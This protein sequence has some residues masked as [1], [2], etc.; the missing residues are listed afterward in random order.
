MLRATQLLPHTRYS[1]SEY[2]S[3]VQLGSFGEHAAAFAVTGG[4]TLEL[5]LAQYWSR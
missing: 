3:F 5:T 1:D 2:R 4:A